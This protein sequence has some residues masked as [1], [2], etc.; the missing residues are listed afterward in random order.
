MPRYR[1]EED[2]MYRETVLIDA[3]DEAAARNYE[4]EII[5]ETATDSHGYEIVSVEEVSPDEDCA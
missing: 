3:P 5:D 1:V 2:R 4:G